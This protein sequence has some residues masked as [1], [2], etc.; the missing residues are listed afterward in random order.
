M[1]DLGIEPT[2]VSEIATLVGAGKIAA[3][4]EIAKQILQELAVRVT[5]GRPHR[6]PQS[7]G[8]NIFR[9]YTYG[10]GVQATMKYEKQNGKEVLIGAQVTKYEGGR[11][12]WVDIHRRKTLGLDKDWDIVYHMGAS[13]G[14]TFFSK[15]NVYGAA[16]RA[17]A[18]LRGYAVDRD[19]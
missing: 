11:D 17:L 2:F 6:G 4:K 1:S 8:G 13:R 14:D 19:M 7:E 5:R 18:L 16:V 9:S 3:S 10:D 12:Y 15:K